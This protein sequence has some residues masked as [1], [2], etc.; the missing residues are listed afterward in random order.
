MEKKNTAKDLESLL[1]EAKGKS[2]M[3][4]IFYRRTFQVNELGMIIECRDFANQ[5]NFFLQTIG[6]RIQE[7]SYRN[8]MRTEA[9]NYICDYQD[10]AINSDDETFDRLVKLAEMLDGAAKSENA[11][12]VE[13]EKWNH[14][15]YVV[16]FL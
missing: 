3:R 1:A 4:V 13:P 2:R 12:Y 6:W 8:E 7:E 15:Q 14:F 10:F 11:S 5:L 16:E 9:G